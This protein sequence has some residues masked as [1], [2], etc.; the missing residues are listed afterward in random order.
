[1]LSSNANGWPSPLYRQSLL[2][3]CRAIHSPTP[4][5]SAY[6]CLCI[7]SQNTFD[8]IRTQ[9]TIVHKFPQLLMESRRYSCVSRFTNCI[10]GPLRA[11]PPH[12]PPS[13]RAHNLALISGW[14]DIVS[15]Q[16][17][18]IDM[19]SGLGLWQNYA[20]R[21]LKMNEGITTSISWAG[22]AFI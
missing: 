1:M 15:E 22:I 2:C 18:G 16:T 7:Y 9:I 3:R 21:T 19:Q 12:H 14:L 10:A 6:M 8:T 17:V 13:S 11:T 20:E 5:G 4:S